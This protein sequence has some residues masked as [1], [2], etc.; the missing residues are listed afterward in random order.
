MELRSAY[1]VLSTHQQMEL[2]AA[3]EERSRAETALAAAK[4]RISE[5]AR[6]L[7]GQH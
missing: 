6:V 3:V 1:N 7:G 2:D 4:L 5:A